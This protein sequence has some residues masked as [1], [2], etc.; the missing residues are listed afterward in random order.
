MFDFDKMQA[1][2]DSYHA[3][4]R[5]EV[6]KLKSEPCLKECN[7]GNRVLVASGIYGHGHEWIRSECVVTEVA[8]ECVKV[9]HQRNPDKPSEYSDWEHWVGKWAIV[10]VLSDRREV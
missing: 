8:D 3:R 4:M 1:S 2:A 10:D 6:E 9:K 5:Q 7:V